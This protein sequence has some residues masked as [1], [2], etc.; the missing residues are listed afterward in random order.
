[1]PTGRAE[2]AAVNAA[3]RDAQAS[4]V[5][6]AAQA[7][8]AERVRRQAEVVLCSFFGSLDWAVTIRWSD[9]P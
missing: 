5:D 2:V 4:L 6:S 1:M 3:L 9:R 7:G 8:P